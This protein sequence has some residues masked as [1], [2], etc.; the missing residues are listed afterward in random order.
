MLST[1]NGELVIERQLDSLRKQTYPI[2]VIIRDDCSTDRT[3]QIVEQYISTYH[4]NNW[5]LIKNARN[6]GW[7][8]NFMEGIRTSEGAIVFPCDQDDVWHPEKVEKMVGVMK[9]HKEI[10]LLSCDMDIKYEENA[11]RAKVYHQKRKEKEQVVARYQFTSQFFKNPRP[12]CSYAIRRS[13]IDEVAGYWQ[14]PYPHDEFLWLMASV[15]NGAFFYNDTLMDY[16]RSGSSLS[17]I[18]YKNIE[19]QKENLKYIQDM[20]RT[21]ITFSEEKP[22]KVPEA[23]QKKL[24]QAQTWCAKRIRLMDTRNPICWFAMMP[25]WPFYNSVKNCLSDLYLVL[26][27]S[28]RR[29]TI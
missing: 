26:F 16:I 9:E 1:Y 23:Y 20:L 8:R 12:G 28:F 3:L 29:K 19:M 11:I 27:G 25:Y 6:L 4:L 13:F 14:E 18:R 5:K 24:H 17:D 7:K 21:M 10:L 2:R 22:G 15:Q